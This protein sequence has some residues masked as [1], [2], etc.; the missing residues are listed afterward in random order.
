MQTKTFQ[1]R[2]DAAFSENR[3]RTIL[4]SSFAITAVLLACVGLYGVLSCL[5]SI[6]RRE[7]GLRLALGAMRHRIVAGFLVQ[8]LGI[9]LLGCAVGLSIA[10]ALRSVLAGMLYGVSP[11]DAP[12][13]SGVVLIVIA[14]AGVASLVPA[15]RAARVEPMQVLRDE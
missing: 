6:R 3:L 15:V 8:G 4:L 10:G 1:Q 13:L 7:V 12:T 14:V 2:L 11:S 9:S 5:V